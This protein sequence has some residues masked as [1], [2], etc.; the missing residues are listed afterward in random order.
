MTP[1]APRIV[2]DVSF[3]TDINHGSQFFVA[4]AVFGKGWVVTCALT[5]PN[6][7]RLKFA[8]QLKTHSPNPVVQPTLIHHKNLPKRTYIYG[9]ILMYHPKP[10]KKDPHE[11]EP[12][13]E[14]PTF[15]L[16]NGIHCV[17]C[18]ERRTCLHSS[19]DPN[20]TPCGKYR[21]WCCGPSG[22]ELD[23]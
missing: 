21:T 23:C 13:C 15:H 4:G 18:C 1:V 17:C 20:P 2:N 16:R 10:C 9:M 22:T 5:S 14:L 6:L 3:V 19:D 12:C 11:P 7:V 8:A